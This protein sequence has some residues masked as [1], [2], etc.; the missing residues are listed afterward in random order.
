MGQFGS[1]ESKRP[2]RE[3]T[4]RKIIIASAAVIALAA[5]G[6][7]MSGLAEAGATGLSYGIRA[8]VDDL[9][10]VEN[11]QFLF[12]GRQHCW[13]ARGWHGPGWYWCG[14]AYR[15]GLGWGGEAGWNGWE[16]RRVE[17]REERREDR[18]EDRRER[19]Y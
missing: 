9:N 17:R 4:M 2:I 7:L 3:K 14:Y 11:A 19:R 5:S 10:M 13:Y 6:S 16:R 12:E 18:R 15:R 1:T 8:A